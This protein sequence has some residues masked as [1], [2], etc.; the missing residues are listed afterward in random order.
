M[1]ESYFHYKDLENV[2]F[3]KVCFNNEWK[4]CILIGFNLNKLRVILIYKIRSRYLYYLLM[5]LFF[6]A[7]FRQRDL[8]IFP[9]NKYMIGFEIDKLAK[10]MRGV[11]VEIETAKQISS[12]IV[13]F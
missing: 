1:F 3:M 10:F 12:F 7:N 5:Q 11:D 2:L 8:F 6:L 9:P 4:F 13:S